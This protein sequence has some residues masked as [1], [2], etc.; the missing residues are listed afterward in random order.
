MLSE[1][2]S[3]TLDSWLCA[4]TTIPRKQG[5]KPI[6]IVMNVMKIITNQILVKASHLKIQDIISR[7][8]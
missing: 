7:T 2:K 3:K 5:K 4:H 6:R 1:F 8:S